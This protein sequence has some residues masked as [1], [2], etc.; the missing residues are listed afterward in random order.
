[1]ENA[2]Y[3]TEFTNMCLKNNPFSQHDPGQFPPGK[4][5]LVYQI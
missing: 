3:F 1:M 2:S 4:S 5:F